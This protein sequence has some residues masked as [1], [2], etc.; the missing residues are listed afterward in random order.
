MNVGKLMCDSYPQYIYIYIVER[1]CETF[2]TANPVDNTANVA[3][4][5][6]AASFAIILLLCLFISC[7]IFLV[8]KTKSKR[9]HHGTYSPS[10]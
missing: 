10:R 8:H 6:G 4:I 9:K 1:K 7:G 5:A 3:I 2:Q